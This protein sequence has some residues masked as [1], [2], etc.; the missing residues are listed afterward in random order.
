LDEIESEARRIKLWSD[1]GGVNMHPTEDYAEMKES[2]KRRLEN[3]VKPED[4]K[5]TFGKH[6]WKS[7]KNVPEDYLTWIVENPRFATHIKKIV[8]QVLDLQELKER[9]EK[10]IKKFDK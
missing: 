3:D 1:G 6:K 8:Q 7:W 2:S 5:V 4:Q 10:S 9:N